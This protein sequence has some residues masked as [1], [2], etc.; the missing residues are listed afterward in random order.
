[1]IK[2]L[3]KFKCFQRIANAGEDSCQQIFNLCE[4]KLKLGMTSST[5]SRTLKQ[6]QNKDNIKTR[7][8]FLY[9]KNYC[10]K[11]FQT[12]CPELRAGQSRKWRSTNTSQ[13]S[14]QMFFPLKNA[15]WISHRIKKRKKLI[16][17]EAGGEYQRNYKLTPRWLLQIKNIPVEVILRQWFKPGVMQPENEPAGP[18]SASSAIW[19]LGDG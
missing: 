6:K 10:K 3:I 13:T 17:V 1:M 15:L 18:Y 11:N 7:F 2:S 9:Y 12:K 19:N 8:Y 5:V 16:D 4:L 14:S